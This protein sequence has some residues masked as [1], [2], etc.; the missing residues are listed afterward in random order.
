MQD[1]PLHDIKPLVEVPDN[2]FMVLIIIVSIMVGLVL[3]TV[4][5]WIWKRLKKQKKINLKKI[6]MKKLYAI[7]T[8]HAKQAA[9]EISEYG[10]KLASTDN[11]LSLLEDLDMRLE[12][13]KYKKS[14]EKID[15]ETL[16][17]FK[18]FLEVI[19]AT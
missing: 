8:N 11:E 12:Q 13:Y 10:R 7:D 17:H 19:D 2:S 16:G 15:E 4:G 18:V 14:V 9:Y 6:Y 5:I 3:I 1:I